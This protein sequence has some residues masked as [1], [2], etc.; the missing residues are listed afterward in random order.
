MIRTKIIL[1]WKYRNYAIKAYCDTKLPLL[2]NGMIIKVGN[3]EKQVTLKFT[4]EPAISV[5][6]NAATEN[7]GIV[8]NKI[9][10]SKILTAAEYRKYVTYLEA[11][12]FTIDKS[13]GPIAEV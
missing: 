4:D 8:F 9:D 13:T 2:Y 3:P 12:G 6:Y 7:L 1:F 10:P 11:C 5:Q